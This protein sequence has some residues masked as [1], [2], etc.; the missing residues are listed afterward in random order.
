MSNLLSA[1]STDYQIMS[2]MSRVVRPTLTSGF[3]IDVPTQVFLARQ[4]P[5][6]VPL[7]PFLARVLAGLTNM[8]VTIVVKVA[9]LNVVKA[10]FS[11]HNKKTTIIVM[12]I[13]SDGKTSNILNAIT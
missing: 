11:C 7:V 12:F 1:N 5:I 8:A 2:A 6:A 9:A 13:Q 10:Q 3:F 4:R